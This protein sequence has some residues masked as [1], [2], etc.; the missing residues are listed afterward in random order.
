MRVRLPGL[1]MQPYYVYSESN[2]AW[3]RFET[4]LRYFWK[5]E[6]I[7]A[8]P[9][10]SREQADEVVRIMRQ[11]SVLPPSDLYVMHREAVM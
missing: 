6:F 9:F 3:L 1:L 4:H 2:E 11:K 5:S 7:H 10:A 8:T